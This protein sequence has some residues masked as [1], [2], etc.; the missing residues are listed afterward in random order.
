MLKKLIDDLE[1]ELKKSSEKRNLERVLYYA[2]PGEDKANNNIKDVPLK[3]WP[4][5]V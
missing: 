2:E 3:D 4:K 5:K 1:K